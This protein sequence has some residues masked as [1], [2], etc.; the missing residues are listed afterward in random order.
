[1][2]AQNI[3]VVTTVA[4][5]ER[6]LRDELRRSG[7][8]EGANVRV[9]APAVNISRLDWLTNDEDQARGEAEEAAEATAEALGGEGSVEIQRASKGTDPAAAVADALRSFPA[10]EIVV[11]TRP[12]DESGWLEDSTVEAAFSEF[13][14]PVRHVELPEP[15]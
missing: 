2:P 9:L 3:L 15:D 8:I 7:G 1:M 5:D 14:L 6:Q 10:E 13:G 11:V 4:A 12:G